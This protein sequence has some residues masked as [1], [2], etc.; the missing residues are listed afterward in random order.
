MDVMKILRLLLLVSG[1]GAWSQPALNV[2]QVTHNGKASAGVALSSDGKLLAYILEEDVTHGGYSLWLHDMTAGPDRQLTSARMEIQLPAFSPDAKSI[3]YLAVARPGLNNLQRWTIAGE[4]TGRAAGGDPKPAAQDVDTQVS[5]APDG[6]SL[7]FIR[8]VPGGMAR[9]IVLAIPSGELREVSAFKRN[10]TAVAWSPDGTEIA[11]PVRESDLSRVRFVSVKKGT[12][13]EILTPGIVSALCWTKTALFAT[14]RRADQPSPFQVWS[15][16]MPGGAWRQITHDD[17]GY[18][19][20]ALS[21]SADG[22]LVAAA[23]YVKFQTGLED[24]AA[25]FGNKDGGPRANPD[26][27]LIRPGK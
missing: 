20:S 17:G 12:T 14:M 16:A 3:W 8:W 7:A 27:V 4:S 6:K 19:R 25:W 15:C 13:R 21:A 22:S 10:P 18:M 2:S 26:V 23:R 9:L 1:I 24:L 11:V 5:F